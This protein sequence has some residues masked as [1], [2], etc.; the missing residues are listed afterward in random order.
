[1]GE[2]TSKRDQQAMVVDLLPAGFELENERLV[3]GRD[4]EE[5]RWI[6]KL[7]PTAH[8]ELRDDRYVAAFEMNRW[9]DQTFRFAYL[10]R[11]VSQGKFTLPAVYVEDMYQP[12][13]FART[14]MSR[15]T[16]LPAK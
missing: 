7:T 2:S 13:Y 4:R 5:L 3:G 12:T 11:A 6:G 15:V 10:V 9:G 8:E 14:R 1:H 16:I